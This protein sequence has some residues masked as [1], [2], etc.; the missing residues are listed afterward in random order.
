MSRPDSAVP[1]LAGSDPLR[2]TDVTKELA[3]KPV[4][5]GVSFDCPP[6][7]VT[8]LLGPNGAGKTTTVTIAAGLRRPGSGSARCF[9]VPC[10]DPAARRL[11][12][13]VPQDIAYPGTVRVREVVRF[14]AAQRPSGGLGPPEAELLERLGLDSL[15]HR[16]IGGLSGGQ[17]RRLAVALALVRAPEL[18]VMDE[19][20]S[21]LD[22]ET[23][24]Q[25]W[26]LIGEYADRG[27][28]VLAT[29]HILGDADLFADRVLVMAG[30]EVVREGTAVQIRGLV[31]G[32]RIR[33]RLSPDRRDS[34]L[35]EL[36]SAGIETTTNEGAVHVLTER[37]EDAVRT[38]L[39]LDP[40]ATE[41]E[42]STPSL[43]EALE[44]VVT[45]VQH[46]TAGCAE[47]SS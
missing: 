18:L 29:T 3:R 6:G 43:A 24:L 36:H 10:S 42:V 31:G 9:G 1:R 37:A 4:L 28:A 7:A 12:A 15:A 45:E 13:V 17:R 41:L 23:R 30:G 22:H 2:L 20:T 5:T 44:L 40:G 33:V 38:I 26:Q 39:V 11:I 16:Q 47:G 19:A 46:A 34:V 32:R 21:S 35:A 27:G 25:V 8:V 14:V